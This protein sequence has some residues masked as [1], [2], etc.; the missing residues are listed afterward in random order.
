M[1]WGLSVFTACPIDIRKPFPTLFSCLVRL[2]K[3]F[4][5]LSM[6]KCCPPGYTHVQRGEDYS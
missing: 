6:L 1:E 5:N 3:R 4:L 2:K